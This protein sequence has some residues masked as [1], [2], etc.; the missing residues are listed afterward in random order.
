[1]TRTIHSFLVLSFTIAA[2]LWAPDIH[3][4]AACRNPA[5]P[6][7]NVGGSSL[8]AG[9]L[10]MGLTLTAT[11][12][13]IVHEAGCED[14][15]ECSEVPVQPLHHHDQRVTPVEA[16]L[17]TEYAFSDVWGAELQVPLRTVFAEVHYETPNGDHYE[18]IDEGV[19]HRNEVLFGLGDPWLLGRVQLDIGKLALVLRAGFTLPLGRTEENPFA[20]GDQGLT[21]QHIQMGTGTF[22]PV[23]AVEL[24]RRWRRYYL[25]GYLLASGAL[26]ENRHGFLAPFRAQTGAFFGWLL[27]RSTSLESGLEL[28]HEAPERW[29]GQVEQDGSLGRTELMF[30]AGLSQA[31]GDTTLLLFAGLPLLR[32]I[33]TGAEEAILYR[34]PLTLT[35]GIGHT[36]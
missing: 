27:G 24:E 19:H 36:F 5:M 8:D 7:S 20:L 18:P 29:D 17:Q 28:M 9:R 15:D 13:R 31:I 25:R 23:G 3:A 34:S 1:M 33:R 16:R 6:V 11:T 26:Y 10:R 4:C 30:A 14:L 32:S 2:L 35:L 12:V 22:D 21:H